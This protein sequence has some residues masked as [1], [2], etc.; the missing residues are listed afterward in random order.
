[1]IHDFLIIKDGLPLLF[2]NFSIAK[3]IFSETDSL[4]MVSGFFSALNSFSD[5]F[6]DLGTISELKLSNN[7]LKLSFLKASGIP[8]LIYIA[9]Y[10]EKSKPVNVL[11]IL[12]KISRTFLQKFSL[13]VVLN[14]KGNT[15]EFKSFENV[16]ETFAEEELNESDTGFKER[17]IEL[18]KN[19]EVKLTEESNL[20]A[21][22]SKLDPPPNLPPYCNQI[23]RFT[24][25]KKI[26]PKYYLTGE[27]SQKVFYQIDGKKSIRQITENLDLKHAQVYNIC[28]NLIKLGFLKFSL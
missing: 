22:R 4:L 2:K 5:S 23:P 19:V 28:K 11:R 20:Q 3:N 13:D 14:W 26:N 6:E 12:R 16:L 1:M 25:L 27:T 8:N 18:F 21:L 17:M 9:T 10:D 24:T 15:N 7:D